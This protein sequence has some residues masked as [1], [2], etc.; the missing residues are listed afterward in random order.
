MAA[1]HV[2]GAIALLTEWWREAND[3]ADPS[4]A[5]AKA[6]LVN[7]A[8]TLLRTPPIPNRDEGWGRIDLGALFDPDVERVYVDQEVS[9][10]DRDQSWTLRG[11]PADPSLP[12]RITLTWSDAPGA[13]GADPALVNDLDLIV[14]AEDGTTYRG[15]VLEDSWSVAGGS[16]DRLNNVENV[17]LPG[18]DGEYLITVTAH[19]LPANAIPFS[20]REVDQDFALV[21]SNAVSD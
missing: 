1:P 14:T 3:G 20:G 17:F 15:N 8:R 6:L 21:V 10:D 5:M 9:F 12:L 7:T 19:N 11:R 4:P 2:A 18:P 16:A 13:V